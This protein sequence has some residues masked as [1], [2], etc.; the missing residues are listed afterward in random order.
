[1]V[2]EVDSMLIAVRAGRGIGRPLSYQVADDLAAHSLVRLLP[3]FEP[4]PLPVQLVVPSA[5]HLAHKT[6]A[7][8]DHAARALSAL[9]VIR[10]WS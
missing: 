5:R 7:F 2:N 4:Q 6:R 10:G 1:M 3:E 9:E 8:L